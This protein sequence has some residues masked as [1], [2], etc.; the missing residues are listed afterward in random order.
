MVDKLK[1]SIYQNIE[2]S[3]YIKSASAAIERVVNN[4]LNNAVRYNKQNGVINVELCGSEN[5]VKLSIKDNGIGIEKNEIE[6]VFKPYY[7]VSRKKKN[8]QGVGMGLSI[9]KEIVDSLDGEIS[10]NSS[11]GDGTEFIIRLQ[12]Y[13]LKEGD[14]VLHDNMT[15]KT[16]NNLPF[17][18]E[19][20]DRINK[21][22]NVNLLIVEDNI[23]LLNLMLR[24][25]CERYNVYGSSNGINALK[26]LEKIPLPDVIVSDIMMDDMDGIELCRTVTKDER[27]ADIPFI[28]L[29]AR[30][31]IEDKIDG[32]NLGAIDYI[33]KPFILDEL[34]SKIDAVIRYRE[35][36]NTLFEKDKFASL[37]MLLGGISHEIFNPLSGITAPL[38]NLENIFQNQE[39][40]NYLV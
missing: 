22:G 36:K 13:Y 27:F 29:T 15:M 9:V 25:L 4:L 34:V 38:E 26:K 12:R 3:I 37:G 8:I 1:I 35:L 5:E 32:I 23:D 19:N 24:K 40:Q 16:V 33:Y 18:N 10:V 7:Q 14:E 17:Q 6:H 28:F 20:I 31:M 39:Q 30:S 2:E 21:T 11:P